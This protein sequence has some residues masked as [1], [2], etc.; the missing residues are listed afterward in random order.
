MKTRNQTKNSEIL[1]KNIIKIPLKRKRK[2]GNEKKITYNINGFLELEYP[3]SNI[4]ER[5]GS[6]SVLESTI[7]EF[8]TSLDYYNKSK[9]E[10]S[11]DLDCNAAEPEYL[12]KLKEEN[13]KKL[14]DFMDLQNN[15]DIISQKNKDNL[16]INSEKDIEIKNKDNLEINSKKDIKKI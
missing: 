3:S 1:Y 9:I 2:T 15:L 14:N 6:C 11:I 5:F 8:L 16:E 12:I 10:I 13:A 4:F 7:S